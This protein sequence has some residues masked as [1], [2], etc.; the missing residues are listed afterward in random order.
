M[1]CHIQLNQGWMNNFQNDIKDG[2]QTYC[3]SLLDLNIESTK[4][5]KLGVVEDFY[6]PDVEDFFSKNYETRFGDITQ[7]IK[8]G[9]STTTNFFALSKEEKEFIQKF[10]AINVS[11]APITNIMAEMK[12]SVPVKFATPSGVLSL[13]VHEEKLK[14]FDG[15]KIRF[16]YNSSNTGLVLPSYCHYRT[17]EESSLIPIVIIPIS[18]KLALVFDDNECIEFSVTNI[19]DEAVINNFNYH[20]FIVEKYTNGQYLISKT[21]KPLLEIKRKISCND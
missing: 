17:I 5:R 12:S 20:A 2:K 11:R 19:T 1:K 14:Y 9:I 21:E 8:N 15:Y 6:V 10:I 7:K 16:I 4:I 13:A 18:D 3:L